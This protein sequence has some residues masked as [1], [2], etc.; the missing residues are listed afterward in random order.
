MWKEVRIKMALKIKFIFFILLL[1][2]IKSFGQHLETG[3]KSSPFILGQTDKLH[4]K[5]LG[6]ERTLNIYLPEGYSKELSYPVIYLLDGSADEDF[7]HVAGILQHNNFPWVDRTKPSILVGIANTNRKKDF[8]TTSTVKEDLAYIP[9][10]GGSSK[11]IQFIAKELQPYI[12]SAFKTSGKN[13][14]IGQSL[15]GLLALEIL[16]DKPTL[17]NTYIIASPSLWW[18]NEYMLQDTY[19]WS[20]K[21]ENPTQVY[22]GV[23]TEGKMYEGIKSMEEAAQILADRLQEGNPQNLHVHF[24][25]LRDENH[26]TSGHQSILNAFKWLSQ[27]DKK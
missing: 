20:K 3:R 2:G 19:T 6:E 11:F 24:D 7:I 15:G 14:L 26:A 9:N 21:Y 8:T 17:F 1:T 22:I 5:I 23:G 10:N 27:L 12:N 18:R 4:S 13:T 25:H 16:H